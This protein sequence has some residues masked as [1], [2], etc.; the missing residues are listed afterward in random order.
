MTLALPSNEATSYYP[1]HVGT[2]VLAL[3]RTGNGYI[4]GHTSL[5]NETLHP[6][7]PE[8]IAEPFDLSATSREFLH[9]H[10][11]IL[12]SEP[13]TVTA[14]IDVGAYAP[15][16]SEE[17][18]YKQ[19]GVEL[20]AL[21]AVINLPSVQSPFYCFYDASE[22]RHGEQKA[23]YRIVSAEQLDMLRS[24]AHT[25]MPALEDIAKGMLVLENGRDAS[26][27]VLY[28]QTIGRARW[29]PE[30]A[31]DPRLMIDPDISKKYENT[32][33]RHFTVKVNDSGHL[34]VMDQ[35]TAYG[36]LVR[37]NPNY[38]RADDPW[39]GQPILPN[40]GYVRPFKAVP[41]EAQ[42]QNVSPKRRRVVNFLRRL[43]RK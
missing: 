16:A 18:V 1:A 43:I 12:G 35:A 20:G 6:L 7:T 19:I 41:A 40:Y 2:T 27:E 30:T 38:A 25:G 3:P 39:Q 24:S 36:T 15:I 9:G 42:P 13:F 5:T 17:E 31:G 14:D 8:T 22:G 28:R 34:I 21:Q 32:E 37:H 23:I 11:A 4:G 29:L 26:D 33:P 10:R